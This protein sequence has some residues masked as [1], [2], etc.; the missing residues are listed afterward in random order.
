MIKNKGIMINHLVTIVI[1]VYNAGNFL[2]SSVNS[3]INQTYRNLEII[4]IDDGSTDNCISNIS[5][6]IDKRI[7]LIKQKNGGR[8]SAL[9]HGLKIMK[10]DFWMIQ[11]A[12]DISYPERI[13]HQLYTMQNNTELAAAY[14]GTDLLIKNKRIAPTF[15][16]KD[17]LTCKTHIDNFTMPAHDATGMYRTSMVKNYLFDTELRVGSGVDYV[18]RIG[19]QFPI[20]VIGECLYTHRVNTDSITHQDPA[21]NVKKINQVIK[22]ACLRRG[23]DSKNHELPYTPKKKFFKHR[24]IDTILPYAM[25]SV[26]QQR[27]YRTWLGAFNTALFCVRLHPLDYLYYKPSIYCFIPLSL[28]QRYR[29]LKEKHSNKKIS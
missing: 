7:K 21:F 5:D 1:P 22:K 16:H 11:D 4:I 29:T 18:F 28:I 8:A 23:L 6:I 27:Q 26:V 9:N 17:V 2:R 24:T 20:S 19:E 3:I 13:E 15:M 12:D 25:E 14:V 10:G